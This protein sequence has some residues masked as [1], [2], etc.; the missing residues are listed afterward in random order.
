MR[1]ARARAMRKDKAG[2]SL[3]YGEEPARDENRRLYLNL[4]RIHNESDAYNPEEVLGHPNDRVRRESAMT[5]GFSADR[6]I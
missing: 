6:S 3:S 2:L 4:K 5:N 1:H